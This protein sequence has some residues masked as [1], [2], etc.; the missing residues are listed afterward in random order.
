[1]NISWLFNTVVNKIPLASLDQDYDGICTATVIRTT[2]AWAVSKSLFAE[3][4]RV[5][6]RSQCEIMVQRTVKQY[7]CTDYDKSSAL[8]TAETEGGGLVCYGTEDPEEDVNDGILVG[9]TSLVSINL[10]SLHNRIGLFRQWVIDNSNSLVSSHYF[11][12]T[13][14][15]FWFL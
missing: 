12:F 10:P 15:M 7:F 1:M 11:L 13:S 4:M 6:K 5:I 2:T 9:V 8:S 3:R 14:F